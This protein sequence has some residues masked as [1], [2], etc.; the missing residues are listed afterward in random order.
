MQQSGNLALRDFNIDFD[1]PLPQPPAP[2]QRY[3]P[4]LRSLWVYTYSAYDLQVPNTTA[5]ARRGCM[6]IVLVEQTLL[7]LLNVLE[8]ATRARTISAVLGLSCAVIGFLHVSWCLAVIGELG[9]GRACCH[10]FLVS[11]C[12]GNCPML[13]HGANLSSVVRTSISSCSR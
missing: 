9:D 5:C 4:N 7:S 2:T 6:I 11:L 12:V 10:G 3:F 8:D 1:T 13:G